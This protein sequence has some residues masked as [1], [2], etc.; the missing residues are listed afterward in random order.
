VELRFKFVAPKERALAGP[1]ADDV[2][3]HAVPVHSGNWLDAHPVGGIKLRKGMLLGIML[4]L[5]VPKLGLARTPV[6]LPNTQ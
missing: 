1:E 5:S 2:Q 4:A 6:K 3:V